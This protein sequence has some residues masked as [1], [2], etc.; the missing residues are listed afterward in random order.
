M[1]GRVKA[2]YSPQVYGGSSTNRTF[3]FQTGFSNHESIN[4]TAVREMNEPTR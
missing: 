3:R 1:C 4:I 2:S